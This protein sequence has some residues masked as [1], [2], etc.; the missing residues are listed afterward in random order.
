MQWCDSSP[1]TGD[2]SVADENTLKQVD[3]SFY[4]PG[5]TVAHVQTYR[6]SFELVAVPPGAVPI[7]G[8]N[9]AALNMPGYQWVRCI[10]SHAWWPQVNWL[11]DPANSTNIASDE[12]DGLLSPVRT[13]DEIQRR[14]LGRYDVST[15]PQNLTITL[16]SDC[17]DTDQLFLNLGTDLRQGKMTVTL[18]GTV[19]Y[20]PVGSITS[21][22]RIAPTTNSASLL[23]MPGFDFSPYIGNNLHLVGSS[24]NATT[25]A[26]IEAAPSLGTVQVAE[27][28][29]GGTGGDNGFNVGDQVEIATLTKVSGICVR[30][31]N[32]FVQD[33]RFD[34]TGAIDLVVDSTVGALSLA[35]CELRGFGSGTTHNVYCKVLNL[36][37]CSMVGSMW[38]INNGC[39]F[40][41]TTGAAINC[42][43]ITLG[44]CDVR[45][46]MADFG[47]V[48]SMVY[49]YDNASIRL[50]NFHCFGLKANAVGLALR[51]GAKAYQSNYFYGTGNDPTSAGI[52]MTGDTRFYAF[53][54]PVC[55]AGKGVIIDSGDEP[56]I[57]NNGGISVPFA[58]LPYP[59]TPGTLSPQLGAFLVLG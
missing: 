40:N 17:A 21:V 38:M 54:N 16:M 36:T 49:G 2:I 15:N 56:I 55:D 32:V 24:G 14:L 29:S 23:T 51:Y 12:N 10:E 46:H 37:A 1:L 41:P 31:A 26:V 18:N 33:C 9:I 48:N 19:K 4:T 8:T 43:R 7:P 27:R 25:N 52:C 45:H 34:K 6:A 13:C 5:M 47:V 58:S 22:T 44:S 59:S 57:A 3:A 53:A 30:G 35:R 28:Y 50:H 42:P 11:W 39:S 20:V